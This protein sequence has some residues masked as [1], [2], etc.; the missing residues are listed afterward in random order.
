MAKGDGLF[1]SKGAIRVRLAIIGIKISIQ[2]ETEGL[3]G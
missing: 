2:T 3:K 1:L